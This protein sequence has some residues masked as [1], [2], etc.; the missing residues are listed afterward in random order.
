MEISCPSCKKIN[1]FE[2][3]VT[4][5]YIDIKC[6]RC[7]GDVSDLVIILKTAKFKVERAKAF[8]L[9]KLPKDAMIAA[10]AS[11]H[12]KHSVDAA[13]LAF[14]SAVASKDYHAAIVWYKRAN[15]E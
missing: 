12:L 10:E 7:S 9:N 1:I 15:Q 6:K 13:K 2:T 3:E 4:V 14:L 11:W 5:N 8:L